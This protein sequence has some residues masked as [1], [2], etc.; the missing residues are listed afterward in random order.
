MISK[1]TFT[2]REEMLTK[3]IRKMAAKTHEYVGA[4]KVYSAEEIKAAE[5]KMSET[6]LFMN[7]FDGDTFT[8]ANAA[9]RYTSPFTP[10]AEIN[11][12]IVK[13][14]ENNNYS[15]AVA[16]GIPQ[17]EAKEVSKINLIR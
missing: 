4:G 11:S 5:R 15:Y 7:L 2:G 8:H 9:E 6:K 3:G 10:T 12:E 13:Q 1:V 16:H 14:M 17:T